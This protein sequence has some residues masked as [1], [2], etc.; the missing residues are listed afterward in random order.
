MPKTTPAPEGAP[1][2]HGDVLP[3]MGILK[4]C[5]ALTVPAVLIAAVIGVFA[6]GVPGL[7]STLASGGVVVLFFAISLVVAHCVGHLAPKALLGAF[8]LTYLIK[9]IGFGAFLLVPRDPSWFSQV[10]ATVGA[11]VAT[12]L[13][14]GTEMYRF[15]Q[16]RLRVFDDPQDSTTTRKEGS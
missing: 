8:A 1:V 14:L 4:W 16:L 11:V 15:S 5:L 10:W 7:V 6:A 13:W 2:S 3:W 9:V 12:L